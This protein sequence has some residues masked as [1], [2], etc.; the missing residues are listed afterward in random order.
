[1]SP[2][3]SK[4]RTSAKIKRVL[5][6]DEDVVVLNVSLLS[7]VSFCLDASSS[8][9]LH[10]TR[11]SAGRPNGGRRPSLVGSEMLSCLLKDD[12]VVN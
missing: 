1:M 11:A 2:T 6:R 8:R 12:S 4:K 5:T 3:Y 10:L 9:C 7:S